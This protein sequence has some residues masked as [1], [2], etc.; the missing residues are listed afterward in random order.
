MLPLYAYLGRLSQ[1]WNIRIPPIQ[2]PHLRNGA[3]M[4]Y[5][6]MRNG[7]SISRRDGD[8]DIYTGSG[9]QCEPPPSTGRS[10]LSSLHAPCRSFTREQQP[11]RD[12]GDDRL[13]CVMLSLDADHRGRNSMICSWTA[14]AAANHGRGYH[15]YKIRI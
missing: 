3:W 5:C 8:T 11:P 7:C 1:P 15:P 2:D 4:D 10:C 9:P 14:S 12:D 13:R 6:H